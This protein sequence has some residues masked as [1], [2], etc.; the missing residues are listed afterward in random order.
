MARA[1]RILQQA[2]LTADAIQDDSEKSKTLSAI[3]DAATRIGDKRQAIT[4]VLRAFE[5]TNRLRKK[6]KML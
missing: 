3:A 1:A 5:A 6:A 2:G 4:L